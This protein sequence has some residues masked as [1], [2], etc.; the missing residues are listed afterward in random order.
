MSDY[1]PIED[2]PWGLL[3]KVNEIR[4]GPPTQ[5]QGLKLGPSLL[6]RPMLKK[7]SPL[8]TSNVITNTDDPNLKS[9]SPT[10]LKAPNHLPST[11]IT[12]TTAGSGSLC[13]VTGITS[14]GTTT[15]TFPSAA[16]RPDLT[17]LSGFEVSPPSS[18]TN[19]AGSSDSA[20]IQ[21]NEMTIKQ[22][23]AL[24]SNSL[25][26]PS[27]NEQTISKMIE[28]NQ[29]SVLTSPQ[30]NT[31]KTT[32]SNFANQDIVSST[33]QSNSLT[34]HSEFDLVGAR[35]S[36]LIGDEE[37]EGG[38][39]IMSQRSWSAKPLLYYDMYLKEN[40]S[41]FVGIF[42][43]LMFFIVHGLRFGSGKERAVKS[44]YYDN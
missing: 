15:D 12:T 1:V 40:T 6:G 31:K 35:G 17:D 30:A 22:L 16:S 39:G 5:R 42:V 37:I 43:L 29:L 10:S 4:L 26:T 9:P 33:I 8:V 18:P 27:L 44:S 21:S 19:N 34:V 32:P 13:L 25:Q 41:R 2:D 36:G 20:N 7:P 23:Q 38:D 3:E 24:N 14:D 28:K 11:T